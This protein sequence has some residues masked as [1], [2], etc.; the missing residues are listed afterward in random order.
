[1]TTFNRPK[2]ET[3]MPAAGFKPAIPASVRPQRH[4][5]DCAAIRIG[6]PLALHHTLTISLCPA[7]NILFLERL[8]N[9]HWLF[10]KE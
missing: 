8:N 7:Y 5:F 2:R 9:F 1:M 4:A 6:C 10:V 3:S